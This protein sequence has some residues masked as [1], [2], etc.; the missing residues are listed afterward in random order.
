MVNVQWDENVDN[1]NLC[2]DNI[3][4]N[5]DDCPFYYKTKAKS[6]IL[7]ENYNVLRRERDKCL[8]LTCHQER[9]V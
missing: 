2:Q 6:S 4:L 3:K 9:P 8:S 7:K 5:K 1:N